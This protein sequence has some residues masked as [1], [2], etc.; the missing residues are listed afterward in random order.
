MQMKLLAH[1]TNMKGIIAM[2]DTKQT[3]EK[4]MTRRLSIYDFLA[5]PAHMYLRL[6]AWICGYEFNYGPTGEQDDE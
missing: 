3:S 5:F 4:P 1:I 6:I 2:T